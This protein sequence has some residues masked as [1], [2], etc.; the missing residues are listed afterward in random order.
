MF[1]CIIWDLWLGRTSRFIWNMAM[2]I[3]DEH[4]QIPTGFWPIAIDWKPLSSY[5][6]WSLDSDAR[7]SASVG[8]G[9][10]SDP[11]HGQGTYR[12]CT[13]PPVHF[14][15]SLVVAHKCWKAALFTA[16]QRHVCHIGSFQTMLEVAEYIHAVTCTCM[17]VYIYT[18]TKI[19]C[20]YMYVNIYI[21]VGCVNWGIP[22]SPKSP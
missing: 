9:W 6:S 14:H 15:M 3:W 4:P 10:Y 17:Y 11:C 22:K 21:C 13:N 16:V 5:S 20:V 18:H 12:S 7:Q 19:L 2:N 1:I 8:P